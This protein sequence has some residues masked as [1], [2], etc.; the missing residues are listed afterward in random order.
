MTG[1]ENADTRENRLNDLVKDLWEYAEWAGANIWEVP[2]TLP[3]V[4]TAAADIIEK[5]VI[6]RTEQEG[7]TPM[8]SKNYHNLLT[9]DDFNL[10]EEERERKRFCEALPKS[11]VSSLLIKAGELA[12]EVERIEKE[13]DEILDFL[14]GYNYADFIGGKGGETD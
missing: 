8:Y 1:N 3:A 12:K 5:E 11:V 2:I 9:A 14:N 7:E 4:L 13:R 6:G 10:T